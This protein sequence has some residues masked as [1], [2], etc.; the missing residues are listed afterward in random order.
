[1]KRNLSMAG[2]ALLLL[3]AA[4]CSSGGIGDILGSN[5][6]GTATQ[7]RGTVDSVDTSNQSILLTNVSGNG[8]MLSSGGSGNTI[9]VY[10][11]TRTTVSFNGQNYRPTDLERGD[12]VDVNL[13][14]SNSNQPL[15]TSMNVVYNA[16][17]GGTYPSGG[18]T[19]PG[20]YSTI[21]GVVRSVDTNR[22]QM[23]VQQ[24]SNGQNIVIPYNTNTPVYY[25]GASYSVSN[26]E[27]GDEIDVRM[28]GS[29]AQDV[30]VTHSISAS[31]GSSTYPSNNQYATVR[32]TVRYIDT[33]NHTIQ[34]DSPSWINGFNRSTGSTPSTLSISY[35]PSMSIIV[36]GQSYPVSGLE[37]GD[38]IDVQ[39]SGANTNN[40]Y[41]Q[42]MTLVRDV[43]Q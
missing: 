33:A 32:G 31:T 25:N 26:L 22:N 27:I 42:S 43:R 14:R 4:A 13:D 7:V 34:I 18:S 8:S 15:A 5:N 11:D 2:A 1:M 17:T 39:V 24:T 40:L 37:R 10:Y 41:A 3:L 16:R 28:N 29:Y 6:G 19:Y 20:T 9:R 38:V 35:N 12:Q 36:N 30:T 21:H 23:T